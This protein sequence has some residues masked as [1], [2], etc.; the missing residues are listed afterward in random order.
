M[1]DALRERLRAGGPLLWVVPDVLSPSECTELM[2]RIDA[3]GPTTA[4]V[5]TSR[6]M[7]MMPELRNNERV[8]FDDLALAKLLYRRVESSLPTKVLRRVPVGANE[9]LRC[10]RYQPGQ[11]FAPHFDGCFRRSDEE[12]SELTLMVY[13]NDDF[14]GGETT[15]NDLEHSVRPVR[16]SALLFFHTQRHEGC[17][18][19][20]GV[21]YVVRSD[22]MYRARF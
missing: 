2:A 20:S 7:V 13:L 11:Y 4:P 12:E 16:G 15:F 10:Y 19:T 8:M 9:R 6:G 5:T 1:N 3:A 21:K 14:G 17:A 22:V 18:V